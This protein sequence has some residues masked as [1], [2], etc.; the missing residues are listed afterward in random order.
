M[1]T[2]EE[3][4]F[5]NIYCGLPE[6]FFSRHRPV[7]LTNQFPIHFNQQAAAL[8]ELNPSEGTRHDLR[9]LLT[10][11][12]VIAGFDPIAMCYAGHQFGS[13]VPRLGDGRALLLGQVK[14]MEGQR[15]DIQLKGSGRTLYSR[16]GDGKAVLRSTIR[17]YLCSAAMRG[18]GIPTTHALTL[19]GSDEEVYR[20]QVE[21]GALLVR[22]AP[23]HLRFGSF[24]YFFYQHRYDDLKTLADFAIEHYFPHL[25]GAPEMYLLWL[26]EVIDSTA[27]LIAQWQSVGFCHGVMNT[28]NMS[29][30]GITID[31]GPYGFMD[32]YRAGH[33]CNQSD[34]AGRYAFNRQPGI[35]LFNLSC[36]AQAIL[37]LLDDRPEQAAEKATQEL[38]TYEARFEQ[39]MI[40]HKRAKL[41]LM[42]EMPEDGALYDQLLNLL[43]ANQVDFTNFFRK[44]SEPQEVRDTV[45]VWF[46]DRQGFAAWMSR[47]VLRLRSEQVSDR[48]RS[49]KM[50]QVNPKYVLRNYL[51][52]KAIDAARSRAQYHEIDRLMQVL[53]HP[54]DEQPGNQAYA[55]VPPDWSKGLAVSCSS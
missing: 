3:L 17:E 46:S 20:E 55:S 1:K 51:A 33:I 42:S 43:E 38:K 50:K 52:E 36:L 18:L 2:F 49:G 9:D 28:D 40:E 12:S 22:L 11:G 6:I 14:T 41:G 32:T 16:Q 37:P 15:W 53:K 7:P 45:G 26:R 31:Y 39:F 23:S 5:D 44:L 10:N 34:Y 8:I 54:F 29:I 4:E 19:F 48:F 30:H 47:Y 13:Y 21:T 24:E 35:G 25:Q 27:K